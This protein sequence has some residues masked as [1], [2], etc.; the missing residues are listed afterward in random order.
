MI[1]MHSKLE[2][3][4]DTDTPIS[5]VLVTFP[6]IEVA[7]QIGTELVASQLV[8]CVNLLPKIESIYRWLGK[9]ETAEECLAIFKTTKPHLEA[10]A[11]RLQGSHPYEVPEFLVLPVESGLEAYLGWVREAVGDPPQ[12]GWTNRPDGA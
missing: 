4:N 3:Q 5:L 10:L 1:K 8:A 7:R 9:V 2:S 11:S 12:S 6:S